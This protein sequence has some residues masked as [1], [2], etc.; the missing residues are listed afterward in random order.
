MS[1][2]PDTFTANPITAKQA[3][4]CREYLVDL[5]GTQAAVRAG[6]SE[7]TARS[8]AGRLLTNVDIVAEVSRL[9][10]E[11]SRRTDAS[12]D[13]VVA[14]LMKIALADIGEAFNQD[15][16]MKALHEMPVEVRRAIAGI[17]VFE[18]FTGR[19]EDREQIGWTKKLRLWDKPKALELLGRHLRMFTDKLEHTGPDG[20]PIAFTG[21]PRPS[22]EEVREFATGLSRGFTEY[23]HD[24][25][26][27]ADIA[28][29]AETL[30][31]AV[32]QFASGEDHDLP[33]DRKPEE[34]GAFLARLQFSR[35]RVLSEHPDMKS[36]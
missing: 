29:A 27:A 8:Q 14:E 23:R 20:Q 17:D 18:E 4:F 31:Y 12:A 25:G 3:A 34:T 11:R 7:K 2:K 15:G 24:T 35:R 1:H 22:P 6:Y 36:L 5:N 13:T 21:P 26:E 33:K 28:A 32:A 16:S 10:E 9:M 19:G 30:G